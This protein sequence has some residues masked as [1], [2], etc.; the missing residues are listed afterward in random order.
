MLDIYVATWLPSISDGDWVWMDHR[1][2]DRWVRTVFEY[3]V[4]IHPHAI[5]DIVATGYT[6]HGIDRAQAIPSVLGHADP[7]TAEAYI[8]ASR[9]LSAAERARALLFQ[10]CDLE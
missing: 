6:I 1:P 5:R 9:I 4:G 3:R 10:R 2:S 7:R 8:R